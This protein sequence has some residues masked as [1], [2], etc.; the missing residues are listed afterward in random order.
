MRRWGWK[1]SYTIQCLEV[2]CGANLKPPSH[3][4]PSWIGSHLDKYFQE[5]CLCD[6]IEAIWM[7]KCKLYQFYNGLECKFKDEALNKLH[8]LLVGNHDGLHVI[9]VKLSIGDNAWCD[10]RYN[11]HQ[12]LVLYWE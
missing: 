4:A 2:E 5:R 3:L 12:A 10:L 7:C 8:S 1:W 11:G 6:F 9:F